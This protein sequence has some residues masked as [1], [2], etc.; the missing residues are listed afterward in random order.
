MLPDCD[1]QIRDRTAEAISDDVAALDTMRELLAS[2]Q[3]QRV[4]RRSM[5]NNMQ[6]NSTRFLLNRQ[7]AYMG[8]A[9][10]CDEPDESP[11][12]PIEVGVESSRID[13]FV[14]WMTGRPNG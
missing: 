12:G 9:A 5:S 10:I 13:D 4:L 7:A 2:R 8:I 6:K 11:L 1:A 3:L 14:Q